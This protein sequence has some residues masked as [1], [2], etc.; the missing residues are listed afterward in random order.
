MYNDGSHNILVIRLSAIGDVAM[1]IPTIYSVA[2]TYPQHTLTVV[3]TTFAARLFIE[4]P[5]NVCVIRLDKKESR[6][7]MGTLRLLRRLWG[8]HFDAV[9]D[10]HNVLRSWIVDVVF[11]LRGTPVAMLDKIRHERKGILHR[12]AY[13]SRPFIDRYFD[14]FARLGLKAEAQF[15][16]IFTSGLPALPDGIIPKEKERWVGIAPFARYASKTY[17]V[18]LMQQVISLLNKRYLR[19]FLFGAQGAE[20]DMLKQ[21]ATSYE[22][23]QVVAGHL[24]LEQELILMAHMDVMLT[25]DSANMH[26]ASLVGTRV[27]SI[28]GGTT[29]ACGFLGFGQHENDA[30]VAGLDCQPCSIAGKSYCQHRNFHCFTALTPQ[31]IVD[32]VES[33]IKS[34]YVS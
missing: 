13:T 14:V 19:I 8:I 31:N 32:K 4:A 21:W 27:V 5:Q 3:T 10:L 25:M 7:L 9:A 6:G 17:N 33:V 11:I 18:P 26:M 2:R 29:P 22:Q 23:V 20:T 28:W 1:T 34:N 16:S 15:S 12:H 24:S 30:L